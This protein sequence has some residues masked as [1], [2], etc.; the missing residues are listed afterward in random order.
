[1]CKIIAPHL[2]NI[3]NK[4]K[5]NKSES[6]DLILLDTYNEIAHILNL[7]FKYSIPIISNSIMTVD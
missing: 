5:N 4:A 3:C 1:M 7:Y 6:G 2:L